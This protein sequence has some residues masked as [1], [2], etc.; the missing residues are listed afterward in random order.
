MTRV[1]ALIAGVGLVV[2]IACFAGVASLG[3]P[4]LFSDNW[5]HSWRVHDGTISVGHNDFPSPNGGGPSETREIAWSGEDGLDLEIPADVQF[6][7]APGPG[8]LVITGP[9][10]TVDA[11]QVSGSRLDFSDEPSNAQR[12]SVVMTAPNVHRFALDGEG[13]I[14]IAGFHQDELDLDLSGDGKLAAAGRA[15]HV[16][17][18]I[19]GD[20]QADLA[21]LASDSAQVNIEGSGRTT[22]A[23]AHSADL[24]I[25]GDGE[26]DLTTHPA[27]LHSDVSGSGRIVQGAAAATSRPR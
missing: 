20:G 22:I 27:D 17:L 23:P 1:L 21:Q 26:V 14:T 13:S 12:V 19:S 2:A 5:N 7:Q 4:E 6:T 11:L 9:K 24:T 16:R 3:G 10:G 25:S 15:H 8:K 18:D